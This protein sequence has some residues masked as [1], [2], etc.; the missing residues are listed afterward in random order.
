MASEL[1]LSL[2]DLTLEQNI[3]CKT[4]GWLRMLL[5]I[6]GSLMLNNNRL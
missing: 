3:G 5:V 6:P 4:R 2:I 1:V